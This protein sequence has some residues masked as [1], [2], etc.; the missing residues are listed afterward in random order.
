M[1]DPVAPKSAGEPT[2]TT[3]SSLIQTRKEKRLRLQEAGVN[4]YPARSEL[5]SGR[6]PSDEVRRRY[7]NIQTGE[8]SPEAVRFAGRVMTRRDMGKASFAHLQ[9]FQGR[10]Q[11]YAR[12]D[13][14]G[15]QA[16]ERFCRDFDLGDVVAVE[17]K[18]FRTKTGELSVKAEKISLL[19]K[20][21]RPMPEKWHGLKDLE[22]RS[23]WRELDLISN[24]DS[25]KVFETRSRVIQTLRSTL[26]GQGYLEVETPMMQSV[27][28]GAIARPFET[29]H[30]ALGEKFYL[31][32]AP[33]LYLKRCLV[34]GFE[35]VFE[36]G[37]VF[38]NEGIDS[39]H[40]PEFTILEAYQA[41]GNM[42]TMMELT[43]LLIT[44]CAKHAAPEFATKL[45]RP[46]HRFTIAELF[47]RHV[48]QKEAR[49]VAAQDW[50]GLAELHR[51]PGAK[52]LDYKVYDH[53]F[54]EKIAPHLTEPTFVT[55]FPSDF[56]PLAKCKDGTAIAERFELYVDG[57]EL[58]NAYSELND[59][60]RQR[61]QLE[62]YQKSRKTKAEKEEGE[63]MGFD[64]S[65]LT[66]LEYGM[67]PAGGLGIGVDRLIMLL[68]GQS[69]IRDVLLFP[70]L[71]SEKREAAPEK[72]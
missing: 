57:R 40:N 66:A 30:N 6:L 56:S 39:T 17:G 24:P 61:Q 49:L 7:E 65:F 53:L 25:R 12:K 2:D 71:K 18:V 70:I 51:K 22:T 69:S 72:E 21:L 16:Y 43:E 50:T 15:D 63:G 38:R 28:G 8:E 54:D 44:E 13:V 4:P 60:V 36:I 62:N 27:P 37:R 11:I 26:A 1:T 23:R 48:G 35:K 29:Y 34:G 32:V 41:Y 31:R 33:E 3:E 9:D 20:S 5:L 10:L 45:P 64:E 14:L 58:A 55:E 67:P 68:T 42:D 46:F 59:P 47:E 52:E 19:S